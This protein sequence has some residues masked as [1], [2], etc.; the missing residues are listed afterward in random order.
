MGE[1]LELRPA[2]VVEVDPASGAELERLLAP[3]GYRAYRVA[4][5]LEPGL[6]GAT[7]LFNA[8]YLPA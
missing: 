1:T 7:G 2:L 4:R 3:R 5:R 6:T 8:V